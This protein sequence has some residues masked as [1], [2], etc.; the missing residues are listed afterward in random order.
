MSEYL[1]LLEDR[2][3]VYDGAMG[4]QIQDRQLS[5]AD[6]W[7]KEGCSEILVLSRP[8]VIRDIHADYLKV[9]ADVVETNTFGATSIVLAEYDLQDKVREIN[10]QAVKLAKEACAK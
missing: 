3:L 1:K 6:Y 8:D 10:I 5:L 4:T 9:G 7:D 2:I